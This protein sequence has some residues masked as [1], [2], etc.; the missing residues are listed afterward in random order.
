MKRASTHEKSQH[1]LDVK[2]KLQSDLEE[3]SVNVHAK[4]N[5][6]ISIKSDHIRKGNTYLYVKIRY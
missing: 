1:N 5:E 4:S 2:E 3:L 6:S